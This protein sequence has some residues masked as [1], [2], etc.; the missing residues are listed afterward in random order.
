M[1]REHMTYVCIFKLAA[2]YDVTS[3]HLNCW[4]YIPFLS[5]AI[6]GSLFWFQSIEECNNAKEK[7]KIHV[8]YFQVLETICEIE[9]DNSFNGKILQ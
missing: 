4:N 9:G 6:F 8:F 5:P 3:A 7:E 1:M 2:F